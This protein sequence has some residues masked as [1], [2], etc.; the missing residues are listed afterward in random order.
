MEAQTLANASAPALAVILRRTT[1]DTPPP[2]HDT[3]LVSVGDEATR[4]TLAP[5]VEPR[6]LAIEI[7]GDA[8]AAHKQLIRT[9]LEMELCMEHKTGRAWRGG[10]AAQLREALLLRSPKAD[11]A[12]R[13]H[14][15]GQRDPV[16]AFLGPPD[17]C[18]LNQDEGGLAANPTSSLRLVPSDV[19][20]AS[21][22][23]CPPKEQLGPLSPAP[24]RVPLLSSDGASADGPLPRWSTLSVELAD[25]PGGT[26]IAAR[27]NSETVFEATP[28]EED[29]PNGQTGLLDLAARLPIRYPTW[30]DKDDPERYIALIIPNWQLVE[31]ADRLSL[32]PW[33]AE[34]GVSDGVGWLLAEP[35]RL[36]VQIADR[37][38]DLPNLA[39]RL[40]APRFLRWGY[41]AGANAGRSPILLP[42]G[43]R[44]SEDEQA[45]AQ[46]ATR[47]ATFLGGLAVL[48]VGLMAALPRLRDLFVATPVERVHYWPGAP[49]P[50]S[51]AGPDLAEPLGAVGE[52]GE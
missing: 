18:L 20:A 10:S 7:V 13:L 23:T 12:H 48:I 15:R 29:L 41:L 52:G 32:R 51:G 39:S 42:G 21:L 3:L 26:T 25:T 43:R 33:S 6:Y 30:G 34:R 24:G 4:L 27:L 8:A 19:W 14:Y 28:L 38:G 40:D 5:Y 22:R 1:K 46:G 16:P 2:D 11:G 35:W 44:P 45:V 50:K 17:A 37:E 47:Q 31:A 36:F 9:Q 49:A